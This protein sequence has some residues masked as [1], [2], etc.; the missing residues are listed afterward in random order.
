[1]TIRLS[2]YSEIRDLVKQLKISNQI[3]GKIPLG[4]QNTT[5]HVH[6]GHIQLAQ[7]IKN[8]VDVTIL[9]I[10]DI[11]T[12]FSYIGKGTWPTESILNS[13]NILLDIEKME[14]E[15]NFDYTI[16][17]PWDSNF[18]LKSRNTL[19]SI[20]Y[21][22]VKSEEQKFFDLVEPVIRQI[23]YLY[24]INLIS[25]FSKKDIPF[26]YNL[27]Q[28]I[29]FYRK[30]NID[31]VPKNADITITDQQSKL[32]AAPF[33]RDMN[34][35]LPNV[36]IVDGTSLISLRTELKDIIHND[37]TSANPYELTKKLSNFLPSEYTVGI[38]GWDINLMKYTNDYFPDKGYMEITFFKLDDPSF[39]PRKEIKFFGMDETKWTNISTMEDIEE[40]TKETILKESLVYFDKIVKI[41]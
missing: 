29:N 23:S 33:F 2:N 11:T 31:F 22:N 39:I 26:V 8:K 1:M 21:S 19:N 27:R 13:P 25:F 14:V 5:P 36:N 32:I 12:N 41:S 7:A 4:F 24:G 18:A 30:N 17:I 40:P 3:I 20:D 15:C 37:T 34:G 35:F 28:V 9:V 10:Q 16:M 6:S 38:M